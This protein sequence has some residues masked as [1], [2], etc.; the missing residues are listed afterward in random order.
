MAKR[1]ASKARPRG[2][3]GR[4]RKLRD[5]VNEGVAVQVELLGAAVQVW[6]TMFESMAAYT[7]AASEELANLSSRGDANSALDRIIDVARGKL[8]RLE[9]LPGEIG[10]DFSRKVRARAKR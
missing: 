9:R 3:E 6:S 5:L 1:K 10:K 4:A 8:D 7:R 2:P